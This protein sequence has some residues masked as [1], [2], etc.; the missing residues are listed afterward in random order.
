[1]HSLKQYDGLNMLHILL[2]HPDDGR[3]GYRNM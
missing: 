2:E 3:G 1:M